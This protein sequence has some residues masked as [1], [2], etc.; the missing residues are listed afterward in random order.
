MAV[1]ASVQPV[2]GCRHHSF[3]L[4]HP[5][6]THDAHSLQLNWPTVR[7]CNGKPPRRTTAFQPKVSFCRKCIFYQKSILLTNSPHNQLQSQLSSMEAH[8]RQQRGPFPRQVTAG[9]GG[10]PAEGFP[11]LYRHKVWDFRLFSPAYPQKALPSPSFPP[12][13]LLSSP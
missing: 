12:G 7:Y 6:D 2:Q 3:E 11:S 5:S 4:W 10:D 13:Y 8:A 9:A 1:L